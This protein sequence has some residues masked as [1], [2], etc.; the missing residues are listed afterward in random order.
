MTFQMVLCHGTVVDRPP[1]LS[2]VAHPHVAMVDTEVAQK[3]HIHE[4]LSPPGTYAYEEWLCR[5]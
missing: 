4:D 2:G 3:M 5:F 1:D